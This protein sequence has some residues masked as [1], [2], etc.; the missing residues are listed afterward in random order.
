MYAKPRFWL[1][2]CSLVVCFASGCALDKKD[3]EADAFRE[4]VPQKE[5][6]A[7]A[8]PD[9]NGSA[10]SSTAAVAP[11]LRTLGTTP[12]TQYAKWYGFTREMRHGVNQVTASVLGGVW[13]IL[14]VAPTAISADSATWGPY[15]D[16]LEPASYRFSITRVAQDEYRYTLDGRP[17]AS[18]NEADFR[19]VLTG[20]GYGKP[21]A[22]YGQGDFTIDLDAAKA[23]DPFAHADDSGTVHID[24]EVPPDFFER[25]SAATSTGTITAKVDPEGEAEYT[26]ESVANHDRSGSIH[27]DAHVD[28]AESKDTKLED[29][30]IDSRWAATGA[31]RA[32][33]DFTGGDLP[34]AIPMVDAVECWGTDFTQTYYNDSVAFS[35]TVGE[36][37]ACVYPSK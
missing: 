7:L 20:H 13:T 8:G 19:T 23:L 1:I 28:I 11:S 15:T 29:V 17:K 31:G 4:A 18:T 37:S 2:G 24:Y 10:S 32:D 9:S 16:A 5:S 12:T 26:V 3:D 34:S 27:V 22:L 21:H 14:H 35:P 36:E 25:K 6:V 30:V 33:I